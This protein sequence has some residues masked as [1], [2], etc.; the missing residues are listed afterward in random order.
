MNH[1]IIAVS[2][3]RGPK[4]EKRGKKSIK[5]GYIFIKDTPFFVNI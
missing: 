2:D 1:P 4:N 5:K 3:G